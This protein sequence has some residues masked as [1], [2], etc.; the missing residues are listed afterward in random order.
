M[1]GT[2]SAIQPDGLYAR[3]G[4]A[5]APIV[6]DV[7]RR[8]DFDADDRVIVG[9]V[10]VDD[11]RNGSALCR[12]G[13][14]SSSAVL[15]AER[16]AGAR[17]TLRSG[18]FNATY[19]EGAFRAGGT[20]AC[21]PPEIPHANAQVGDARAPQDRS[22]CLSLV[23]PTLHRSRCGIHLRPNQPRSRRRHGNGG[24]PHDIDGVEFSHEGDRC[25]FD[26][27]LRIYDITAPALD[28]LAPSCAAPTRR[29]MISRRNAAGC[30][31]FSLGLSTN[32]PN[33]HEMLAHGMVMYD[34]L[35]PGVARSSPKPTIGG[36]GPSLRSMNV[37]SNHIN[38][39]PKTSKRD[40]SRARPCGS[41]ARRAPELRRPAGRSP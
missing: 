1:D 27:F 14:R 3:L 20:A 11:E 8:D 9:A 25:S 22:H 39:L 16:S 37:R 15:T 34:A 28:H 18:H 24:T 12:P 31:R 17:A 36:K 5:S 38:G 4:A 32:F 35:L 13:S 29:A 19:L 10:Q 33:D 7:R 6:V 41:A 2:L 23:D 26:T 30:S 21:H 40:V